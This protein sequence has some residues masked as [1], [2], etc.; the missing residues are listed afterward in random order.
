MLEK[1]HHRDMEHL[2]NSQRMRAIAA[3]VVTVVLWG[4]AFIAIRGVVAADALSPGQLSS[5]RLAIAAVLLGV[6][7]AVRRG[8]RIPDRRDWLAF[9]AL[10]ATGQMLYH[11]LLNTGE[12]TVDGGT[13][14][15]LIAVA[16]MLAALSAVIF[17]GE[18]LTRIGW[19]GTGLAFAGAA[20]IAIS[21]GA[22]MH[23]GNGIVLSGAAEDAREP[24]RLA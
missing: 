22:S 19:A 1:R 23:G 5:A 21:S 6:L 9:F 10:G 14:S 4:S 15:L 3:L 20:T 12:R 2:T 8:I 13:A 17:L 18:R 24:I 16:P 7:V 11:L